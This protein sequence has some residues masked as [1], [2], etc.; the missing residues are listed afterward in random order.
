MVLA[1]IVGLRAFCLKGWAGS[2]APPL[3]LGNRGDV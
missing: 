1:V 3:E 2:E